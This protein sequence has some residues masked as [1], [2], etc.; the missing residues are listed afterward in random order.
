MKT[1]IKL[2]VVVAVLNAAARAGSAAWRYYQF[3]DAVEQ[4]MI[5]GASTPLTDLHRQVLTRAAEIEVPVSAED[6]TVQR[7]AGRTWAEVAYTEPVELFP[8]YIY[9]IDF[10][11]TVDGFS[12]LA[13]PT[14]GRR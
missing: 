9:P 4:S 10:R 13:A 7:E 6:V 2:L 1:I 12:V 8:R 3:K 14:D 11:F 5:F